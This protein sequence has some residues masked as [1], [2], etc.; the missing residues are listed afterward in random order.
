MAQIKCIECGQIF[1][2]KQED[3]P[4]CGCP[5]SESEVL[6]E[7]LANEN[8]I[9]NEIPV[10]ENEIL[11]P[12]HMSEHITKEDAEDKNKQIISNGTSTT[13]TGYLNEKAV[14]GYADF[15]FICAS[16][17]CLLLYIVILVVFGNTTDAKTTTTVGIVGFIIMAVYIVLFYIAKAF[18]KIYANI[19]I[20]LHEINMKLK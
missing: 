13:D 9:L 18:V 4:K 5:A 19:S 12:P 7:T 1:D 17:G 15:I 6:N 3:C 10:N 14:A 11:K 2:D 16:I 20:N 8:E